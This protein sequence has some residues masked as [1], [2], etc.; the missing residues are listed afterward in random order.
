MKKL[1][2]FLAV[3]LCLVL[4]Q[5][6]VQ[7]VSQTTEVQAATGSP[8]FYYDKEDGKYYY[9]DADGTL[10][11]KAWRTVK[12]T[13][14]KYYFG[15][16]GAAYAAEKFDDSNYNIVVKKIGSRKY[17]FDNKGRMVKGLWVDMRGNCYYFSP[18]TGALATATTAKYQKAAKEGVNPATLR[19][20]LDKLEKPKKISKFDSCYRP[21]GNGIKVIYR[22]Y[23]LEI[24]RYNTGK[25]VVAG[26][27]PR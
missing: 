13:G 21:N 22:H 3:L 11:K 8:K 14:A 18:K 5:A 23:Y 26:F 6:P 15:S 7:L 10:V 19:K 4:V 20:M 24:F 9:Q 17:G 16:D 27:W 25:Q 2:R 12:K 1:K